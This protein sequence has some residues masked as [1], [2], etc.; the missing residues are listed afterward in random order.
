MRGT[1]KLLAPVLGLALVAAACGDDDSAE[2][3]TTEAES[4]TT[5]AEEASLEGGSLVIYSGRSEELV[6]P[7]VDQ[8]EEATGITV[9]IR[10]GDT[11]EMAAQILECFYVALGSGPVFLS[12]VSLF[13]SPQSYGYPLPG[14]WT[15]RCWVTWKG[16]VSSIARVELPP[17]AAGTC[18][19]DRWDRTAGMVTNP[20]AAHA[21]LL[22]A[23]LRVRD[24]FLYCA[25]IRSG[26]G[27]A[28]LTS[29]KRQNWAFCVLSRRQRSFDRI[30][31]FRMGVD[32]GFR[33]EC[34][35]YTLETLQ[36]FLV[37]DWFHGRKCR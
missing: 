17:R 34:F 20:A 25:E 6:G 30:R 2:T 26:H 3:T 27:N 8:F 35:N 9:E 37:S 7:L 22:Y 10:Y 31:T 11:A 36:V 19:E 4:T 33:T 12:L 13:R 14:A 18:R 29:R 32:N 16:Q 24:S 21:S 5:Q 1:R 15:E 23:L 28:M